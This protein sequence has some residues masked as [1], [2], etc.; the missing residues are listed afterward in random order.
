ME[1]LGEDRYLVQIDY[2][3]EHEGHKVGYAS[4][5]EAPLVSYRG[6]AMKAREAILGGALRVTVSEWCYP[7]PGSTG[8][9][10][11]NGD[12]FP[13][14]VDHPIFIS[15]LCW[16]RD[17][18]RLD[19]HNMEGVE[20]YKIVSLFLQTLGLIEEPTDEDE[21]DLDAPEVEDLSGEWDLSDLLDD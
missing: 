18:G 21:L 2:T 8:I 4:G 19:M 13:T 5:E 15:F 16:E 1:D 11:P 12:I 9:A 20:R 7:P 3:P 10:F 6:A 17:T 14:E